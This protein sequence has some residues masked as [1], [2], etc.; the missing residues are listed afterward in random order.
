MSE[1]GPDFTGVIAGQMQMNFAGDN[2]ASH[3]E[4]RVAPEGDSSPTSGASLDEVIHAPLVEPPGPAP[5]D[6]VQ[7]TVVDPVDVSAMGG[8]VNQWWTSP[9]DA[10][11][12][13]AMADAMN[14]GTDLPA[15]APY[16]PFPPGSDGMVVQ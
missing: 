9:E 5:A 4:Y 8:G 2:T 13:Q 6:A 14:A 12:T 10:L 11:S 1:P 7:E 3:P 16:Q 15:P